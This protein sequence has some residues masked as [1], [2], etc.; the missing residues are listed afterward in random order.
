MKSIWN[1]K[2]ENSLKIRNFKATFEPIL[3][4]GSECWTIDYT[5]RKK[6]EC[7][8]TRLLRMATHISW[9]YNV[10]NTQLYM[11]M[12]NISE[13]IK[14]R[15]SGHYIRHIDELAFNIIAWKP[16]NGI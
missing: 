12:P 9:K 1:S 14:Q 2:M 8:Y 11:G 10:T 5:M 6:I 7:C 4:Y 16:K 13:V 15:I 3:L